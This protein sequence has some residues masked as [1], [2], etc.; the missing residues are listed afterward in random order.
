MAKIVPLVQQSIPFQRLYF[1]LAQLENDK[2][3]P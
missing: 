1:K 2:P 3:K